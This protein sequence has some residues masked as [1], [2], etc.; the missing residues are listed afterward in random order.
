VFLHVLRHVEPME[1]HAQ[2]L[3]EL[4]REL[5]LAD[6]GGTREQEA[7]GGL[8]RASDARPRE[9]DARDHRVDR[10]VLAEDQTAEVGFE[11]LELVAVFGG[12]L[13]RRDAGDARDGLFDLVQ[14]DHG[15]L[16][17]MAGCTDLVEHV[18]R[19]VGHLAVGDVA[20]GELH[21]RFDRFIRVRELVVLFVAGLQ[22]A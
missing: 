10:G 17:Q 4:T 14:F 1:L 13:L 16:R 9:L 5:G 21:A 20:G 6:P 19:L 3:R 22:P 8:A 11:V 18:D 12:D 15:A 7:A 2:V